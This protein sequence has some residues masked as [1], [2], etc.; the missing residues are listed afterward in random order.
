MAAASFAFSASRARISA[1]NCFDSFSAAFENLRVLLALPSESL[2]YLVVTVSKS[3]WMSLASAT[4]RKELTPRSVCAKLY[5]RIALSSWK[6]STNP[7]RSAGVSSSGSIMSCRRPSAS[8]VFERV[9]RRA[10]ALR[11]A[12]TSGASDASSSK[13]PTG[14]SE[15]DRER[16]T[17]SKVQ[18]RRN[19][20]KRGSAERAY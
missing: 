18:D 14:S 20:R 7:A 2:G 13:V 12:R 5:F 4:A 11:S 6:A 19:Q 3:A 15:I 16:Q 8:R 1:E 17:I 10:S 9:F